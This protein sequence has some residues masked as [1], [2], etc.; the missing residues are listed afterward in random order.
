[1]GLMV[2]CIQ[3]FDFPIRVKDKD[4]NPR[5]FGKNLALEDIIDDSNSTMTSVQVRFQGQERSTRPVSGSDPQWKETMFLPI[6]TIDGKYVPGSLEQ[7]T[8]SIRINIFDELEPPKDASDNNEPIRSL[9]WL[10]GVN[11]PF[12]HV[13][14]NTTVEG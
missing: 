5:K 6:D 12:S 14:V 10:G 8:D 7:V 13:Y 1:M 11:I 3:G 4:G 2:I 9:S